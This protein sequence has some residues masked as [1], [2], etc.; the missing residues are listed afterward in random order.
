MRKSWIAGLALVLVG[1]VVDAQET[2]AYFGGGVGGGIRGP[3]AEASANL[4]V[5]GTDSS[6]RLLGGW[7]IGRHGAV[8]ATYFRAGNQRLVAALD[9]GF[10]VDVH[11]YSVAALG[12]MGRGRLSLFGKVGAIRWIE[13]GT[14]VSIRG[15]SPYSLQDDTLL[16][17]AG[18]GYELNS[19]LG[20][21]G[22][23]EQFELSAPQRDKRH[24][25]LWLS[26][27]VHF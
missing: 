14:L 17:G 5:E 7:E 16:L 24:D 12:K 8:E 4:G 13:E 1:S 11:G 27:A 25:H 2:G 18:V 15:V 22:E 21:R 9:F 19:R 26:A 3:L 10:D 20:V 23:W 6:Y